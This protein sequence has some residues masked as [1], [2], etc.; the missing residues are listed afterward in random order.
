MQFASKPRAAVELLLSFPKGP[1]NRRAA[2]QDGAQPWFWSLHLHPAR[3][4]SART[5]DPAQVGDIPTPQGP[6]ACPAPH[7]HLSGWVSPGKQTPKHHY[8]LVILQIFTTTI[9]PGPPRLCCHGAC[10]RTTLPKPSSGTEKR[11]GGGR[12]GTVSRD[13]H[14]PTL[15]GHRTVSL[16]PIGD[17]CEMSP[18]S[19]EGPCPG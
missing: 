19:G 7:P 14:V 18:G 10:S 11:R 15:G 5:G 4:L 16:H 6:Q 12:A 9:L 13:A 1:R 2:R 8:V 17:P 3:G